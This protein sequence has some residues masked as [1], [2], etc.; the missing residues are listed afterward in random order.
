M[1]NAVKLR[2]LNI[3]ELHLNSPNKGEFRC[4]HL[5]LN[6]IH[7]LKRLGNIVINH[8][9]IVKIASTTSRAYR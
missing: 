1:I 4:S 2:I 7:H 3:M 9:N 6:F 5:N 8:G